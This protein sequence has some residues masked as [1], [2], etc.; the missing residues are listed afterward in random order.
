[1]PMGIFS[2]WIL[3]LTV[4]ILQWFTVVREHYNGNKL[5]QK[6]I[7]ALEVKVKKEKL[8][9]ELALF[10]FRDFQQSVATILPGVSKSIPE[11]QRRTIASIVG[12]PDSTNLN[13]HTAQAIYDGAK[14]AFREQDYEKASK[15]LQDLINKF[16]LS[17]HIIDAHFL[18]VSLN[19]NSVRLMMLL[20]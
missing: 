3:I 14:A 7:A 1:M 9:T 6:K 16:P 17:V 11:Y 20:S 13:M 15:L 5:L 19:I 4:A 8:K 12:S 18:L 2:F 10:Q